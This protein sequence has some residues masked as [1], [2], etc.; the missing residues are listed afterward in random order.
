MIS[1]RPPPTF[2]DNDTE[3]DFFLGR[4]LF[5]IMNILTLP[6]L[7]IL[8][9]SCYMGVSTSALIAKNSLR[10]QNRSFISQMFLIYFIADFIMGISETF[11]LFK[12]GKERSVISI[13]IGLLGEDN[14]SYKSTSQFNL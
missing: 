12:L 3:Y 13:K 10:I 9:I 1:S 7:Y 2:S 14:Q 5:I 4:P 8:E 6:Y 11:F